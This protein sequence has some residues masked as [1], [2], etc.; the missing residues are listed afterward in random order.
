MKQGLCECYPLNLQV[1]KTNGSGQESCRWRLRQI[2]SNGLHLDQPDA[3]LKSQE[4]FT[5]QVPFP[6]C[7]QPSVSIHKPWASCLIS[8]EVFSVWSGA[9]EANTVSSWLWLIFFQRDLPETSDS[10]RSVILEDR[11]HVSGCYW[12]AAL[13]VCKYRRVELLHNI[14]P[15]TTDRNSTGI[16][17]WTVG[18][19][20]VWTKWEDDLEW[21]W[22]Q[23]SHRRPAQTK[24]IQKV[25]RI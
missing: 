12:A 13:R 14:T 22:P 4:N 25:W 21:I 9:C 10:A 17:R 1:V 16:H 23:L 3:T 18:G 15:T 24:W 11:F 2:Q 20:I 7:S 6:T 8:P 5:K 19:F